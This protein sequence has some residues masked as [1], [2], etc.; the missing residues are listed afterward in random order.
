MNDHGKR[1]HFFIV[2]PK[3]FPRKGEM[4][5]FISGVEKYF[6]DNRV[7]GLFYHVSRYPR[8][9]ISVI[10]KYLGLA[11]PDTTVRVYAA[12]GD[13][14]TFDCLNG[15]VGLPNAELAIMP[16]GGG[17][18]F[19]RAFGGEYYDRFRD[20]A[21]QVTAPAIPTDIIHCGN[22]YS[23]N[24]CTVGMETAAVIRT[25]PLNKR[26]EKVRLMFPGITSLFY[27]LG[28]VAAAFDKNICGQRYDLQADGTDYSG[29]YNAINVA[30]GPCY[31]SG[32]S[33]VATA[34]PDDGFL[35]MLVTRKM[36]TLKTLGVMPGYLRGKYYKFPKTCFLRRVKKITIRSES[37]LLVNMDGEIFFDSRVTIEL[38]P[39]AIKIAAVDNLAYRRRAEFRET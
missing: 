29:R 19:V 18:D 32:K 13:G 17:S 16:F 22:N 3:S 27:T 33:P 26:F 38:I 21:L 7:S 15:I 30:N 37:P 5:A 9:A 25:I 12:G 35:D 28:G 4:D 24:F 14:I 20:V 31:G 10:R 1:E 2:N 34:V 23:L 11:G 6:R 36:G 39:R 8:D